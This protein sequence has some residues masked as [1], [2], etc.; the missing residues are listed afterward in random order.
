MK[1]RVYANDRAAFS[2]G[3]RDRDRDRILSPLLGPALGAGRRGVLR[4]APRGQDDE[5]TFT[6]AVAAQTVTEIL[7]RLTGFMGEERR[8][9]EVLL[10]FQDSL[11]SRNRQPAQP[12]CICMRK[13]L[14]GRGDGREFL[15]VVWAKG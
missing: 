7:H 8:S 1:S 6:T 2:A 5:I 9:S 10:R 14:W 4:C 11:V 12:D 13:A 3:S 15:G